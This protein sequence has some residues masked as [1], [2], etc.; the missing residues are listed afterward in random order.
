MQ[1]DFVIIA[2]LCIVVHSEGTQR[3]LHRFVPN[4]LRDGSVTILGLVLNAAVLALGYVV[5][6]N[7]T[8]N[9]RT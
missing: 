1:N 3:L 7:V 4:A 2:I 9:V 8:I 6:K 5:A